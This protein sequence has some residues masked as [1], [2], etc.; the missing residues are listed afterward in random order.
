MKG[1]DLLEVLVALL[2][3]Y[4]LVALCAYCKAHPYKTTA[5][6]LYEADKAIFWEWER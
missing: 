4:V 1:F 5:E 3:L 2:V 6:V